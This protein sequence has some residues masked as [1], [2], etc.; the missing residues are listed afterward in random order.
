MGQKIVDDSRAVRDRQIAAQ[1][2]QNAERLEN[3]R[4]VRDRAS[5]EYQLRPFEALDLR[6]MNL[7][8]LRLNGAD[9]TR[10]DLS[11]ADLTLTDLGPVDPNRVP[12]NIP[13]DFPDMSAG[14]RFVINPVSPVSFLAGTKLCNVVLASADLR[15][16]DLEYA[17]F[18]G[19][20]LTKTHMSGANVVGADLS[21][22]RLSLSMLDG[23]RY[24]SST[25]WP[26]GFKPPPMD[27]QTT[28][29][30]QTVLDAAEAVRGK[31]TLPEC[32]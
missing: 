12:P 1:Q 4:F 2:N 8:G 9:F 18:K 13:V 21:E 30:M 23:V 24:N 27:E 7:V 11:G 3:L 32:D 20:D 16:A 25:K 5:V 15:G 10:A 28:E 19:V 17:N 29:F 14:I 6:G 22:A 26:V 31:L